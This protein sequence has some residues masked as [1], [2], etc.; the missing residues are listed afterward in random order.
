M[1]KHTQPQ[2]I[3][4]QNILNI[5]LHYTLNQSNKINNFFISFFPNYIKTMSLGSKCQFC[6]R[7]NVEFHCTI[8]QNIFFYVPQKKERRTSLEWHGWVNDY[9]KFIFGSTVSFRMIKSIQARDFTG[10]GSN[11]H[12]IHSWYI[13]VGHISTYDG[14]NT[15][16]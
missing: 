16:R 10:H 15:L 2:Q 3:Y 13:P 4:I 6:S 9:I 11:Q 12:I 8:F 5:L 14:S 1:H 7:K